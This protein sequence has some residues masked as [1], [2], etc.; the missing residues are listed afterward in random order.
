MSRQLAGR[1]TCQQ[2]RRWRRYCQTRT[3]RKC[4]HWCHLRPLMGRRP[5]SHWRT[6]T[7]SSL[8][9]QSGLHPHPLRL[10]FQPGCLFTGGCIISPIACRIARAPAWIIIAARLPA[11]TLRFFGPTMTIGWTEM[12]LAPFASASLSH[13]FGFAGMYILYSVLQASDLRY[14]SIV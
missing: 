12:P 9:S 11:R 10:A 4:R 1:K 2:G 3:A 6:R 7:E 14:N 8:R 13:C 5:W